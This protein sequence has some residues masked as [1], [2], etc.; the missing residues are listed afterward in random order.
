M[1]RDQGAVLQQIL[2]IEHRAGLHSY[3]STIPLG[4][5]TFKHQFRPVQ[6]RVVP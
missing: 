3:D 5:V 2:Q 4:L 6:R 1:W